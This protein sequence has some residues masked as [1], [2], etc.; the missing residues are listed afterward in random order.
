LLNPFFL[1]FLVADVFAYR[2]FIQSYRANAVSSRPE[3]QTRKVPLSTQILAMNSD[4]GFAFEESDRIGN[5]E[6]GRNTQKQVYMVSHRVTFDQRHLVLFAQRSY[7]LADVF[8]QGTENY[9]F[10]VF[11]RKD[12]VVLAVPPHMRLN[13][14]FSHIDLLSLNL[15]V[16]EGRSLINKRRNGRAYWSLAARGGGLPY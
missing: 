8:A 3:M 12:Y 9:L 11:R 15:A 2:L 1:F 13:C 5:T 14:P 6:F 7:N 4:S 16:H 10:A